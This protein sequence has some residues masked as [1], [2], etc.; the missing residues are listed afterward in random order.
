MVIAAEKNRQ[1]P[2]ISF[3]HQLGGSVI[4][5]NPT[6]VK[7]EHK[8]PSQ[9]SKLLDIIMDIPFFAGLDNNQLAIVAKHMNYFEIKKGE[10]LFKEGDP[11]DSIC[12][13][14]KGALGV[15]K[16][17]SI[18]GEQMHIATIS[19]NKSIGEMAVI[20]QYTRS[21][22]VLAGSDAEIVSLTKRGY[23]AILDENPKVGAAIL[24]KIAI[25]VSMNLRRTSSQ[26]ADAMSALPIT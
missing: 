20:D 5:R 7:I 16:Q 4:S 12:F 15:Y 24:K 14:V 21:A 2:M 1:Q 18:P 22:T 11:G 9:Q 19:R 10:I 25:L 17:S 3:G 13:V 23:D 6:P 26:L 8:K